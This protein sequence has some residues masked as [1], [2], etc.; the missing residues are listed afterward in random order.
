MTEEF[1]DFLGCVWTIIKVI[2]APW[3]ALV[4][5]NWFFGLSLSTALFSMNW[6]LMLLFIILF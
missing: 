1:K 4:V 6:F 2:F 3:L 5:L